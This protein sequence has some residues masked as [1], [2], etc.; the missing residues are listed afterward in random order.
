RFS[1]VFFSSAAVALDISSLSL[2]D[3]LPI[4]AVGGAHR[5]LLGEPVSVDGLS[6][7]A[8]ARATD[9]G[10]DAARATHR[11]AAAGCVDDAGAGAR[12]SEEHTSEL[13]SLTNLVCPL[14]LENR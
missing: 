14:L 3:A 2:H 1:R 9:G 13:Q 8:L 12:R 6:G 11:C 5:A 4:F 7:S 10:A